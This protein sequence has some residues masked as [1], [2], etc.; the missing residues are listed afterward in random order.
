MPSSNNIENA[1]GLFSLPPEIRELIWDYTLQHCY[2]DDEDDH[3]H[4]T[5]PHSALI[6]QVSEGCVVNNTDGYWEMEP[7]TRLLRVNKQIYNEATTVLY[8]RFTFTL[9]SD[10]Y[11]GRDGLQRFLDTVPISSTN[12]IRSVSVPG[13]PPR[14]LSMRKDP[15]QGIA[16]LRELPSDGIQRTTNETIHAR[17]PRLS[18]VDVVFAECW[19]YDHDTDEA[20]LFVQRIE[21]TMDGTA[22]IEGY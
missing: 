19:T 5:H 13:N 9:P 15:V 11:D 14:L 20:K 17:M 10:L 1:P 21:R 2:V 18:H 4:L 3:Y 22:A 8:K 16:I 6:S 7:M 12:M